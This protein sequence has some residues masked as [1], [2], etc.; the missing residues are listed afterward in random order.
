MFEGKYFYA[1]NFLFTKYVLYI[2]S[3]FKILPTIKSLLHY[4]LYLAVDIFQTCLEK[5][6]VFIYINAL[7][8]CSKK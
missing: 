2:R 6:F 4:S 8:L 1:N 5:I 3:T 7:L